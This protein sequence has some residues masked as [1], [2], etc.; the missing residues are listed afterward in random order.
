MYAHAW[1]GCSLSYR[2]PTAGEGKRSS[3]NQ[4]GSLHALQ[5]YDDYYGMTSWL[6]YYF[7]DM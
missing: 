3:G 5:A 2:F 7:I 6:Q 4:I 1:N